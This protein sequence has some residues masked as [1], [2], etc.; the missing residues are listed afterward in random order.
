LEAR[1]AVI[2]GSLTQLPATRLSRLGEDVAQLRA[3]LA[4]GIGEAVFFADV[5]QN[6]Q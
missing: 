1:V 3:Q 6:H 2:I 4:Q 5:Q